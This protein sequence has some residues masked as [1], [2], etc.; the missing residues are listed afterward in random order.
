MNKTSLSIT[1]ATGYAVEGRST[2]I[3]IDKYTV[4][5][6]GREIIDYDKLKSDNPALYHKILNDELESK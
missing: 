1:S 5:I 6:L 2:E 3:D 4:R